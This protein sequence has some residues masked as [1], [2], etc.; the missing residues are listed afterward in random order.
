MRRSQASRIQ[1]V[2]EGL[3]LADAAEK[4]FRVEQIDLSPARDLLPLTISWAT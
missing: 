3:N 2:S 4:C 1:A